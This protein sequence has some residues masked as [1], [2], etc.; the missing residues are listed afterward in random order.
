[1]A[2]LGA[3]GKSTTGPS[4][5]TRTVIGTQSGN[6]QPQSAGAHPVQASASGTMDVTLDWGNAA[7]DF[8]IIVT[9]NNCTTSSLVD[10]AAGVGSCSHITAAESVT[11]K[12]ERVTWAGNG[13]TTY[14]VWV[15]N[16]GASTDSYTITAGV[17]N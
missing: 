17:T 2:A 6:M 8:D 13:G 9:S 7:N 15:V 1:V 10:L 14:R 11:Q 16:F 12:P 3:C 5:P 4:G